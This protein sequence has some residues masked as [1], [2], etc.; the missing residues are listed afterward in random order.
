MFAQPN[1]IVKSTIN[2]YNRKTESVNS[3]ELCLG[4]I[5]KL[6]KERNKVDILIMSAAKDSYGNPS[7]TVM[8]SLNNNLG[9]NVGDL[10]TNKAVDRRSTHKCWWSQPLQNMPYGRILCYESGS[11]LGIATDCTTNVFTCLKEIFQQTG[12]KAAISLLNTGGQGLDEVAMLKAIVD[13]AINDI[14]DGLEL[15]QLMIF[16]NAEIQDEQLVGEPKVRNF[17]GICAKFE[18]IKISQEE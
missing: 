5:S 7:K 13:A 18:E 4:D 9:I 17:E 16:V 11:S 14:E 8:A 6:D 10:A 15:R 3:I 1:F 12:F 2:V